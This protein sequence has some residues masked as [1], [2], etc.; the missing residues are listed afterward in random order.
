MCTFV[1]QSNWSVSLHQLLSNKDCTRKDHRGFVQV[2]IVGMSTEKRGS[3]ITRCLSENTT[4]TQ[5]LLLL[6]HGLEPH[7]LT[8]N[9][10]R[11]CRPAHRESSSTV[12]FYKSRSMRLLYLIFI[13][14]HKYINRYIDT[15]THT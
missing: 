5:S 8:G 13:Y 10:S 6:K 7:R 1:L 4:P 9:L 3:V 14:A 12:L 11:Q 2:H 15:Y